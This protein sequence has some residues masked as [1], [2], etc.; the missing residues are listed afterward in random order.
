MKN[1]KINP[2]VKVSMLKNI[3]DFLNTE[4]QNTKDKGAHFTIGYAVGLLEGLKDLI[5]EF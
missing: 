3:N 1:Y 5:E 2:A 4:E